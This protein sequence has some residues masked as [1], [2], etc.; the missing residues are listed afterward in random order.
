VGTS[1][2]GLVI[3]PS[4]RGWTTPVR[5][6]RWCYGRATPAATPRRPPDRAGAGP[7]ADPDRW[8]SKKVLIGAAGAGYS[9]ALITALSQQGLEFSV[10]YPVTDAVRKAIRLVP[11]HAWQA[12]NNSDGRL[13]EYA[14]VIE[15]TDLLNLSRWTSTCPGMRVIVR[16]E[17]PHPGATLDAFEIRDGYRYQA[18]TTNTRVGQLA[19]LEACH[20]AHGRVEDRSG[21]GRTPAS[22][23]CRPGTPTS[24]PFGSNSP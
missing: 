14:D 16:R 2:V 9:H 3:T 10:G 7:R 1:R 11:E 12:A 23:T 17:L 18:F 22:G 5:P 21:P 8:R 24:M 4:G 20:R 15:V 13:R 6:S 19:I